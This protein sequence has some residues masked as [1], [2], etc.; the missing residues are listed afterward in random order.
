MPEQRPWSKFRF[1]IYFLPKIRNK[2]NCLQQATQ[3]FLPETK[4]CHTRLKFWTI[5]TELVNN[6]SCG[7]PWENCTSLTKF[8][9][10]S[11]VKGVRLK[12]VHP[13]VFTVQVFWQMQM[14]TAS[15]GALFSMDREIFIH[16]THEGKG[17]QDMFRTLTIAES[18]LS[19]TNLMCYVCILFCT[20]YR[21]L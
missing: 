6:S 8:D 3:T 17:A 7:W 13:D 19:I 2:C 5:P 9:F 11:F 4:T 20:S 14:P 1:I 15:G 12:I 21:M 16:K 10:T 18:L